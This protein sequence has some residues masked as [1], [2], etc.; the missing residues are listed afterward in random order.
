MRKLRIP[1]YLVRAIQQIYSYTPYTIGKTTFHTDRGLK[2]GCPLSPL[3]FA[4][5]FHDMDLILRKWQS[6]GIVVGNTKIYSLAYADDIVLLATTPGDL[7][8]MLARLVRYSDRLDMIMSPEKSKVMKFSKGGSSSTQNWPC[9]AAN[10]EEVK[11]FSYLGFTFQCNG[12]FSKHVQ[13]MASNG[14]K[15]VSATWSIG[16]LKSFPFKV[17]M[18]MYYSLIQ[19]VISYG[20]ELFGFREHEELERVQRKYLRWI[21]GLA[22][23]TKICLLRDETKCLP[24]YNMT[25]SRAVKYEMRAEESPCLLLR[26]CEIGTVGKVADGNY[27][28]EEVLLQQGRFLSRVAAEGKG[29]RKGHCRDARKP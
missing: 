20:C 13:T 26:V 25:S 28:A 10:L 22:P 4:I 24:V 1:E 3:L 21:L 16:E 14:A 7:K 8:D 12:G 2:Q 19:P 27:G 6:G 15:R 17:R 18:Q 11:A 29:K 5:Y 9:G 23:W